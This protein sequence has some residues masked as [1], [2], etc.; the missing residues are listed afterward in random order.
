MK[1]W[2]WSNDRV[3][4]VLPYWD[5]PCPNCSRAKRWSKLTPTTAD[6]AGPPPKCWKLNLSNLSPKTHLNLRKWMMAAFLHMFFGKMRFKITCRSCAKDETTL[7]CDV[8]ILLALWMDIVHGMDGVV[9]FTFHKLL[10]HQAEGIVFPVKPTQNSFFLAITQKFTWWAS[11]WI[12]IISNFWCHEAHLWRFAGGVEGITTFL[13][14]QVF[15]FC[16]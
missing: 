9:R 2:T 16:K 6:Q 13:G 5:W 4:N 7:V 10:I 15:F 12:P 11:H 14:C 3:R 1:S 8:W